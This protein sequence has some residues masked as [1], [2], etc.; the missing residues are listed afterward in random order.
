MPNIQNIKEIPDDIAV[1]YLQGIIMPNGE[2]ITSG[3]SFWIRQ[4]WNEKGNS[5]AIA[6]VFTEVKEGE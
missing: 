6:D 3:K 5:V 4:E 1:G 2:F